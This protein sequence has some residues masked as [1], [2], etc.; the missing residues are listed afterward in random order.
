MSTDANTSGRKKN[1]AE[2]L[3]EAT[4][5]SG[6]KAVKR[7]GEKSR[8]RAGPDGGDAAEIGKTFKT[9]PA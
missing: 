2:P 3:G 5:L 7:T 8:K 6:A 1:A 9:P 4:A